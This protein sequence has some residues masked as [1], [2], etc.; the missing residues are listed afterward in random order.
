VFVSES[1]ITL[2]PA[3]VFTTLHALL[4]LRMGPI[5]HNVITHYAERL[6]NDKHAGLPGMFESWRENEVL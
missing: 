6:W 1:F 4:N 2:G 3:T 5:T